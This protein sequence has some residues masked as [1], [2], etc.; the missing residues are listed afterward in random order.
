MQ[1]SRWLPDIPAIQA[2]QTPLCGAAIEGHE[3][4]LFLKKFVGGWRITRGWRSKDNWQESGPLLPPY[5]GPG[6]KLR[7]SGLAAVGTFSG[8]A[9]SLIP[10][11][12]PLK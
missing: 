6:T 10:T 8:S 2:Q 5:R 11:P 7:L 3:F 1:I 9:I 4:L 12:P